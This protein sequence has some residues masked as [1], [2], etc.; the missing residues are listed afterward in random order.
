MFGEERA[1]RDGALLVGWLRLLG[2]RVEI[3][4]V[5]SYW[6]GSA[7][8]FDGYGNEHVVTGRAPNHGDVVS[9]LF[10]GA[11]CGVALKAAA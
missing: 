8:R 5:G 10:Q 3:S 4:H 9:E 7:R 11:L 6:A 1:E 2:W